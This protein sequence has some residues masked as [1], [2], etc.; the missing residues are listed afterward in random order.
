LELTARVLLDR[1]RSASPAFS[2][3]TDDH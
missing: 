2:E 3:D 1:Q